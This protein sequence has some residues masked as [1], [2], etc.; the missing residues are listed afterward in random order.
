MEDLNQRARAAINF[1][2]QLAL[3]WWSKIDQ[4]SRADNARNEDQPGKAGV[5]VQAQIAKI[6]RGHG[7]AVGHKPGVEDKA[8]VHGDGPR[9]RARNS[10]VRWRASVALA[11]SKS[12]RR[13]QL[14]P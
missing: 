9:C 13:S 3:L 14:K 1:R 8:R 11:G 7:M 2:I 10:S 6:Q 5:G 12:A 4:V